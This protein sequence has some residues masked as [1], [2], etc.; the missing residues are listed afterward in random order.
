MFGLKEIETKP[1]S[2]K[3]IKE[4]H[5]RLMKGVRGEEKD[6]GRYKVLQNWIGSTNDILEAKFVPCMP[7][8]VPKL[9]RNLVEYL[10]KYEISAH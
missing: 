7:D 4:I 1:L 9:M 8:S 5:V 3:L 2:E 6:P 10:D